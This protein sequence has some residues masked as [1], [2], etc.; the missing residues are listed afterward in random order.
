M[1]EPNEREKKLAREHSLVTGDGEDDSGIAI[2]HLLARY[3]AELLK[4]EN[5]LRE[6]ERLLRVGNVHSLS[7]DRCNE[8][9]HAWARESPQPNTGATLAEACGLPTEPSDSDAQ[10][11]GLLE[12][13]AE[14]E[15][16]NHEY[17]R[18]NLELA[19]TA[20]RLERER[21][22]ARPQW[23]T[24]APTVP[25]AYWTRDRD[26]VRECVEVTHLVKGPLLV[27]WRPG[28]DGPCNLSDFYEWA[29]PLVAPCGEHVQAAG[30][31]EKE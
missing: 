27:A 9:W 4:P 14:L 10:I 3:R 31:A 7:H 21:D 28:V 19:E 11:P 15:R 16:E 2:G 30:E 18:C 24:Q 1:T 23:T 6:A 26:G 22:A 25:G 17:Q 5:V 29:G 20:D 8:R 13:I 12:R